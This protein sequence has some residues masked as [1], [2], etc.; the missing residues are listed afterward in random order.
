MI[1]MKTGRPAPRRCAGGSL[2]RSRPGGRSAISGRPVTIKRYR[3]A[4]FPGILQLAGCCDDYAA[5]DQNPSNSA[6]TTALVLQACQRESVPSY[7]VTRFLSCLR[8]ANLQLHEGTRR[9]GASPITASG[10]EN[11]LPR[12]LLVHAS[13]PITPSAAIPSGRDRVHSRGPRSGPPVR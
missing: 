8:V 10:L 7:T 13:I 4:S 9:D 5:H 3:D 1:R 12:Y 11:V 2:P 6:R